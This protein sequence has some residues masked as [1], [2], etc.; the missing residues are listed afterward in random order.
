VCGALS[1]VLAA[2]AARAS[3]VTL[4]ARGAV[5]DLP[6]GWSVRTTMYGSR[7]AEEVFR[8]STAA[9]VLFL[10]VTAGNGTCAE[11]FT[12]LRGGGWPKLGARPAWVSSDFDPVAGLDYDNDG[13]ASVALCRDVAGGTLVIAVAYGGRLED[14]DL[15]S[16]GPIVAEIA[17]GVV[18]AAAPPPPP[19]AVVTLP[20][21]NFVVT[22]PPGWT[23]LP[24][25]VDGHPDADTSHMDGAIYTRD[26]TLRLKAIISRDP[27]VECSGQTPPG[28]TPVY[29]LPN[30]MVGARGADQLVGCSTTPHGALIVT[31]F[32][33][34]AAASVA[35]AAGLP[36]ILALQAAIEPA[37]VAPAY[38]PAASPAVTAGPTAPLGVSYDPADDHHGHGD[39]PARW[40]GMMV[41]F[42]QQQPRDKDAT[43][44]AVVVMDE[45]YTTLGLRDGVG[46]SFVFGGMLGYDLTSQTEYDAR[47]GVG[48][49]ARWG[50]L[51]LIP[52][53]DVGVDGVSGDPA[54]TSYAR[55]AGGY[56]GLALDARVFVGDVLA[57]DVQVMTTTSSSRY[58]GGLF[59]PRHSN[60]GEPAHPIELAIVRERFDAMTST[61]VLFGL[62]F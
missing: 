57:I 50:D 36:L 48:L 16:A 51:F 23:Y 54:H 44:G 25:A 29:G 56:L 22:M 35:E 24:I 60:D 47:A 10:E 21:S 6:D 32:F 39:T 12:G 37:T 27:A 33:D 61:G 34:P 31:L 13:T 20:H 46:V 55:E 4:A 59:V 3:P 40:G 45:L 42:L 11:L 38:V 9:P 26:L 5:V 15:A 49:A 30:G 62:G 43:L 19:S 1:M 7:K 52:H 8:T 17:R 14:P 53:L 58:R 18:R 28:M 41:G 2:N